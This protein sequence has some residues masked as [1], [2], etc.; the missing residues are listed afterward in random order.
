MLSVLTTS[1]NLQPV[2]EKILFFCALSPF[3][4]F[5]DLR[6]K[7]KEGFSW[8]F[9]FLSL[10]LSP[11]YYLIL[12]TNYHQMKK[13]IFTLFALFVLLGGG[14]LWAASYPDANYLLLNGSTNKSI[15]SSQV[16]GNITFTCNPDKYTYQGTTCKF[17]G[18]SISKGLKTEG[19][20]YTDFTLTETAS[21]TIVQSLANNPETSLSFDLSSNGGKKEL[22][23]WDDV[24]IT[25]YSGTA[26]AD[27]QNVK[28]FKI[29][30]VPAGTYRIKQNSGQ[31]FMVYV[32]VTY[33]ETSKVAITTATSNGGESTIDGAGDYLIGGTATLTAIPAAGKAFD[34]WE[35]EGSNVST[36]NP[37]SFVVSE[38]AEYTAVF[39]DAATKTIS[40]AS[41]NDVAGTAEAS[42]TTVSE[43]SS[44]TLTATV[45][46]EG[47]VFSNWTKSSD[48]TWTSTNATATIPYADLTDGETYTANFQKLYVVSYD[49]GEYAGTTNKVL[50]NYEAKYNID[51]K[52]ADAAGKYTIPS[53]AHRQLYREGYILSGWTDGTN[54]YSTGDE[55]TLT[56]DITLTPTW[57]ATTETL[58]DLTADITVTWSLAHSQILF[59]SWQGSGQ[60]GYY[61]K[62][63]KI[64]EE[65]IAIPMIVDATSGK[66][67]NSSRSD[68]TD[69][70]INAGTKFTIPA[71]KG[72]TITITCSESGVMTSENMLVGE[73]GMIIDDKTATFTYT[74]S[75]STVTITMNGGRYY[76]SIAATYPYVPKVA[77]EVPTFPATTTVDGGSTIAISSDALIV[78]YQWSDT[79]TTLTTESAGWTEGASVTVPNEA[80]TKYLY[81]YASNGD[82]LNSAVVCESY[83]ITKTATTT[84]IITWDFTNWSAATKA[85]VLAD[86]TNWNQTETATGGNDFGEDG[87]RAYKNA[88]SSAELQYDGTAIEEAKGLKFTASAYGMAVL[89]DFTSTTLGTYQGGSYIWLYGSGSKITIPNVPAG[90]TIE[91]GVES[92]K[93]SEAR[94]VTLNNCTQTQGEAT[95]KAYQVCKW[96]V[97]TTGD[98]T[99]TPT[100]GLHIYYI[101]LTKAVQAVAFTPAHDKSTYVTPKALDFSDVDGLKAYVATDASAGKVTLTEVGAVPAGTPLMLIGTAGTEY[102]VPVAESTEAPAK[103]M[104]VAGDGTT[105]FDG[106]TYDYIL[107][108]DGKFYQIG[109]GTVATTKAYLHCESDPT[110]A[111]S[112]S[113]AISFGEDT[114]TRISATQNNGEMTNGNIFFNLSGQ[115][116]AQPARGLYIVNGK[117]VLVK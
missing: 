51:E 76:P 2:I 19:A 96:T 62:P 92:H 40:V 74:G 69:C 60:V 110:A 104:L 3:P 93:A 88:L 77:P 41:G 100:K 34:H 25:T 78:Y 28:I 79:E 30:N 45:I 91:I 70:Q 43:G 46:A 58:A 105:E 21:V 67:D 84:S 32:G 90:S 111:G 11:V 65:T 102:T 112:R 108:S 59:N 106:S 27:N 47:Y 7:E 64:N 12:L 26:D 8:L 89:F 42:A 86:D 16:V 39:I 38:A 52:Y 115:R 73:D 81:A 37:Y 31:T 29:C 54:T 53:Y 82:D 95:A 72:M 109:S 13:K 55:I 10:P 23:T 57:T 35:L 24:I 14:S 36:V 50:N 87:G 107:Y 98:I 49:L 66:I 22:S 61:T 71:V 33:G 5:F 101:T 116:V 9:P 4:L 83:N 94:G 114:T 48:A 6:E 18:N 103:N 44:T 15:A 17:N 85:G 75:E 80:G 68:R 117:K 20:T 63:Q 56:S 1:A 97:N 113:L 99:V